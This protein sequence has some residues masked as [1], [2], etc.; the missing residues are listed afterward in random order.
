MLTDKARYLRQ[1]NFATNFAFFRDGGGHH[2]RLV[3]A[4]Y[5]TRYGAREV[6]LWCRLFDAKGHALKTWIEDAGDPEASLVLDSRAIRA[7]FDLPEFTGQLFVH[8]IGVAGHDIV[9]YALETYGDAPTVL[10]ATHDANSWP[11]DLT[12]DCPRPPT[13]K[14]LFFGRRTAIRSRSCPARSACRDGP[15]RIGG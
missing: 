1:L 15:R 6:R 5:W 10:S 7:R 11:S 14:R 4:N 9:K 2:T 12:P 13:A 3:T 8:A